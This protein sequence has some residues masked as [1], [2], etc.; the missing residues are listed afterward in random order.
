MKKNELN[1]RR[2]VGTANNVR[3][4]SPNGTGVSRAAAS[5][6]SGSSVWPRI[7]SRSRRLNSAVIA[8]GTTS[9]MKAARQPHCHATTPA[10]AGPTT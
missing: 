10:T 8:I 3:R 1:C 4:A 6:E 7:G 9:T 5:A 2:N